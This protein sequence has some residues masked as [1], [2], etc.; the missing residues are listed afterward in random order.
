MAGN[1]PLL[2]EL[3][4]LDRD[5]HPSSWVYR[6]VVEG[7]HAQ[8]QANAKRYHADDIAASRMSVDLD[9]ELG[10]TTHWPDDLWGGAS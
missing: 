7:A 1:L 6:K 2:P 8:R 10:I 5:F 4:N 9:K 3:A